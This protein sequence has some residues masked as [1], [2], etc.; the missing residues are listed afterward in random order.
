[1]PTIPNIILGVRTTAVN[2]MTKISALTRLTSVEPE[3]LR[4]LNVLWS[5]SWDKRKA[6]SEH[7][8]FSLLL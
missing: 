5:K 6:S 7:L 8:C 1:M 4:S 2:K 3:V